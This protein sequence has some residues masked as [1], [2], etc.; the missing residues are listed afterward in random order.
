MTTLR[1]PATSRQ[2]PARAA[3]K[4]TVS[5]EEEATPE[6]SAGEAVV[7][8]AT[9]EPDAEAVIVAN[10]LPFFQGLTPMNNVEQIFLTAREQFEKLAQRFFG[11]YGDFASVGRDNVEALVKSTAVF[12]KG[13]EEIGKSVVALTQAQVEASLAITRTLLG[14]TTF[15]Q[16]LEAQ[17]EAAK[18][19]FDKLM[20]EGNKI[21]ELS[22]KVTNEAIE[23]IQAR[24]NTAVEKLIKP[25]A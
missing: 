3:G 11:D 10:F 17:N 19:G 14:A 24:V 7:V 22:L 6:T 9:H 15:K 13:A 4:T 21:T 12:A 16:A 8:L 25:A 20:T 5:G 2:S 18:L 23:P 1:K